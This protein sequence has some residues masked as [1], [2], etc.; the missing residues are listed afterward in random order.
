MAEAVDIVVVGAGV[1]GLAVARSLAQA[2]HE[3]LVLEKNRRI[4]EENVRA[5]LGR[6]PLRHLLPRRL[7]QGPPVRCRQR[8]AL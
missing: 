7:S 5:Q 1:V 8:P 2:G 6:H 3:T 4:G